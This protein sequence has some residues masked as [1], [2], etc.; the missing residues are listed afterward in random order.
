MKLNPEKH[1]RKTTRLRGFDYSQ[2]GYYFITICTHKRFCCLGDVADGEM[3]V[4][5]AGEIVQEV[6]GKLPQ[7]YFY[8]CLDE[9]IIM[10]NHVH[11]IIQLTEKNSIP[12]RGGFRNPPLQPRHGLP[13]IVRGFKTWSARRIN[14]LCGTLGEKFWQRSFY[15]HII[16]DEDDL[17]NTRR[18]IRDNPLK[19]EYD[20]ENPHTK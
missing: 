7:H 2:A 15:D 17:D 3:E 6:W 10:P 13:E 20:Q 5:E 16:R 4:S 1:E 8:M 11:G 19:W 14:Q 18:Y 9:F 12:G